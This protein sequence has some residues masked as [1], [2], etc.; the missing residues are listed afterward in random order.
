PRQPAGT[1]PLRPDRQPGRSLPPL[2]PRSRCHRGSCR[3]AVPRL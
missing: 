2:P 3:R 1:R